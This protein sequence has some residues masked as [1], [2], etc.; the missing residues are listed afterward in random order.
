MAASIE[1]LI[2]KEAMDRFILMFVSSMVC[3]VSALPVVSHVVDVVNPTS[4]IEVEVLQLHYG[5]I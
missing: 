5:R 1:C 2:I 4:S 3:I